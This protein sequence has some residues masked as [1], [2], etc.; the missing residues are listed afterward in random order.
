MVP[1]SSIENWKGGQWHIELQPRAVWKHTIIYQQCGLQKNR[2][3]SDKQFQTLFTALLKVYFEM[4]FL[5]YVEI[6]YSL[7]TQISFRQKNG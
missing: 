4:F 2:R 3:I 1:R 5:K 6:N 7:Q